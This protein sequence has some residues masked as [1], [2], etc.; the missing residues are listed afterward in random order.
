MKTR[1]AAILIQSAVLLAAALWVLFRAM[2]LRRRVSPALDVRQAAAFCERNEYPLDAFL[3]RARADGVLIAIARP[4][5]ISDLFAQGEAFYL[6]ADDLTKWKTLG[7]VSEDSL[8]AADTLWVKDPDAAA[9]LMRAAAELNILVSTSSAS[10]FSVLSLRQA[11]PANLYAGRDL[12]AENLLSRDGFTIRESDAIEEVGAVDIDASCARWLQAAARVSNGILMIN[13]KLNL[14]VESSF[15]D[16]RSGLRELSGRGILASSSRT[17]AASPRRQVGA[18]GLAAFWIL[19]LLSPLFAI[20]FGLLAL[21]KTGDWLTI[22]AVSAAFL[23]PSLDGGGFLNQSWPYLREVPVLPLGIGIACAAAAAYMGGLAA[24]VTA[25]FA[26]GSAGWQ[27]SAWA[28]AAP[29][30]VS[31]TALYFPTI[32]SCPQIFNRPI[33]LRGL[34][35]AALFFVIVILIF[36]PIVRGALLHHSILPVALWW[37][38][39]FWRVILGFAFLFHAFFLIHRRRDCPDCER[40]KGESLNDPKP[41][42][43]A[44]IIG[45]AGISAAIG[46]AGGIPAWSGAVHAVAAVVFGSILGALSIG[47]RVWLGSISKKSNAAVQEKLPR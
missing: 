47:M 31:T 40:A 39:W 45:P 46:V 37:V 25:G 5:T 22:K 32:S 10:K 1:K 9:A 21:E 18:I 33:V 36:S 13:F 15:A 43:A 30:I 16:L 6:G 4:R 7:F 19:G 28:L 42:L 29:A 14:N 8:V 20:R 27:W 3:Q 26:L 44:G 17:N 24:C 12:I 34:F 38:P 35:Q 41:W 11:P 23:P 2:S